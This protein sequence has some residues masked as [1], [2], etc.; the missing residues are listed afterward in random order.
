MNLNHLWGQNENDTG[1]LGKKMLSSLN[2]EISHENYFLLC[3][4]MA[5][6]QPFEYL[7]STSET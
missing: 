2:N 6:N 7:L 1:N 3:R 5:P 4:L